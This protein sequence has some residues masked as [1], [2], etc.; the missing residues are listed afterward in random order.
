MQ[1]VTQAYVQAQVTTT[2]QGQLLVLLYDGGIKYLTQAKEKI[3]ERDVKAKG[4]LIS[5]ALDVINELDGSLNLEKGGSLAENLHKLYFY[6]STRLLLA[7]IRMD[8]AL[9]DEVINVLA[10]LRSA[11]AEI[12]DNP[13][14]QAVGAQIAAAQ[15]AAAKAPMRA[16]IAM[17]SQPAAPSSAHSDR[18]R[19]QAYGQ[20]GAQQ[21][22][23]TVRQ[24]VEKAPEPQ[25][26]QNT[27]TPLTP[28]PAQGFATRNLA[29]SALYRRAAQG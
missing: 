9:I 26:E 19:A 2:S 4:N 7:N 11:Y 23:A 3:A 22:L 14:A 18:A 24:A 20:Q 28:P 13:E 6:C 8:P 17:P 27:A 21:V 25:A 16:P 1:K 5:R 10:G 12:L 29:A 15:S